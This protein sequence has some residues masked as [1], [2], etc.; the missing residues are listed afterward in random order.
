[1]K[2]EGRGHIVNI[3]ST[4]GTKGYL[5]Q[6]AYC[7]GK[8]ALMGFS[9]SL[10]LECRPHSIHVTVLCPGGVDTDFIAGTY[11]SERLEGQTML[12]AENVAD[13]VVYVLMQPANVDLPEIVVKRFHVD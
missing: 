5:Y 6:A 9:R 8:H 2:E 7:A 12:E 3:S 1:M 13:L 11:L 10:A 4:S